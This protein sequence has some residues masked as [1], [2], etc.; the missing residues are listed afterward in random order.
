[1]S[2][3]A[4]EKPDYTYWMNALA[5]TF[6]AVHDGDPQ[7]GFY[8][9]RTGKAAGYVPV[10]I[11]EQ[12]G[13]IIAAIDGHVGDAVT[14]WTYCCPHPITEEQYHVRVKTG[15]W[16]DEDDAVT[17][18]LSPPP[19]GHNQADPVDSIK[20]QIDAALKGVG[21]YGDILTDE[22]AAKAQSLRSRLLEL[23]R[24]AD[25]QRETLK[26]PHF[27]AGKAVDELYQPLVKAAK[28]GADTIAKELSAHETRKARVE[29]DRLAA[30]RKRLAEEQAKSAPIGAPDPLPEPAPI[31]VAPPIKGAYGR[32]AAVKIIKVAK[33]VDQDAAY[34]AL[35]SQPDLAA[36]IQK[37]AQKLVDA[38]FNVA[39][40]EV[41][42]ERKVS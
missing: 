22:T 10:A 35:K 4:I 7:P 34:Q 32:A 18:S 26:R 8:R 36:V 16:H 17:A 30:E 13:K 40:V 42:E 33:V 37:L 29:A 2:T 38:G 25:K 23:S 27:E 6:G 19:M 5:G 21:D 15:K 39:G 1:M 41:T 24:D 28:T 12:D 3:H 14:V 20:D 11:W 31:P 9:K